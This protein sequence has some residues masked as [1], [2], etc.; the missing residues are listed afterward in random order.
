MT[1]SVGEG[2]PLAPESAGFRVVQRTIMRPGQELDIR[3]LYVSGLSTFTGGES[4]ARQSGAED[5]N[6]SSPSTTEARESGNYGEKG[7]TGAQVESMGAFGSITDEASA[8]ALPERR[9]TFGT[10]FNAF[11]A[12]Y[13]RR[14][15]NEHEVRLVATLSGEGTFIVYRSTA[16]GHVLRAEAARIDSDEPV[17][18]ELDLPL[19][20]FI[21]GGWYWF[22]VE[23]AH[24]RLTLH[25]AVWGSSP[26]STSRARCRSA[27]PPMNRPDF[28]IDQLLKL[29]HEPDVLALLDEILVVDQGTERVVDH[30]DFDK[31]QARL[32]MK[33]RL[34]EQGNLGGSGGL[35]GS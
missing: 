22:D 8:T 17:T 25:S 30:P 13:W 12:S 32:G 21:D 29:S 27:S 2:A 11:P 23:A 20:P 7:S 18:I 1:D 35:A 19:K 28:C 5:V 33:L 24:R 14:W 16:K 26:S 4:T 10:Y 3:P 31:A 9:L 6:S 34:I 15:T